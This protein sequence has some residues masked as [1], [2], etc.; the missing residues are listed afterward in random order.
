[1]DAIKGE[2]RING[3]SQ[4]GAR[5]GSQ[6]KEKQACTINTSTITQTASLKRNVGIMTSHLS[7]VAIP[8]PDAKK[9][10]GKEH[11]YS[12]REPNLK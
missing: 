3:R 2:S 8:A 1:M 4:P 12:A 5:A 9:M 7:I 11:S 6:R 10:V